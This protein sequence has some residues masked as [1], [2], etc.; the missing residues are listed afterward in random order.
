MM[1]SARGRPSSVLW[2]ITAALVIALIVAAGRLAVRRHLQAAELA[3][4]QALTYLADLK[5]DELS[6]WFRERRGDAAV[7]RS[8]AVVQRYLAA[9]S[10]AAAGAV[11]L[12]YFR[13]LQRAYDYRAVAVYD[14]RATPLLKVG[15]GGWPDQLSCVPEH[16]RR[17]LR[18]GE[19]IVTELHR[20]S[21]AEPVH[22]SVLCPVHLAPGG[23]GP[24]DGVVLLVID[25][26]RYLYPML[27]NQP[28]LT[29]SGE[30]LLVRRDGQEV[31]YLG[32]FRHRAGGALLTRVSLAKT[33]APTVRAAQGETGLMRGAEYRGVDVLAVARPV[34][35]T[36]WSLLA[37]EDQAEV[38][39]PAWQEMRKTWTVMGLAVVALLLAA[40]LAW[41]QRTERRMRTELAERKRVQEE[42]RRSRELLR[43][44][45]DTIPQA[46]FWKDR[47][48]RYL[49]CNRTFAKL[50]GLPAPD[51][52]VGLSDFD[53]PWQRSESEAYRAD[54]RAVVES[55]RAKLHIIE[56]QL[57][58][59]G[60]LT[61][62]DTS[63]APLFDEAGRA[64]GVLGVYDD[65][66]E[67]R[68]LEEELQDRNEELVRFVYTVSHDLR[69][70]LVTIQTFL[71]YLEKD[72]AKG[73][74]ARV[75]A[76]FE[77]I[78]RAAAKMLQ[79]LEELLQLS[80]VGRKTNPFEDVPFRELVR[81]ALD[82]VAG[83]IAE[84]R[85]EVCVADSAAVLRCDRTRLVEVFQNLVD[86]AVK[87][88]GDQ[89][90]PRI[91]IGVEAAG[92]D[93]VCHVRDNGQGIDPRHHS[94][95]FGLFEK[96][97]PGTPGSGMGLA[98]VK[99]IIE[100]HGGRVWAESGGVGQGATFRFTIPAPHGHGERGKA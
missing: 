31:V 89:P 16:V 21:A 49:G 90:A 13:E 38:E 62:V 17:A 25:P 56:S 64:F 40:G 50:A 81:A 83:Q 70:P 57:T 10:D 33:N 9:P 97:H 28:V 91:D 19:S 14:A 68:R 69:S 65:I 67:R 46:V 100:V 29:R 82:A 66:T 85:V 35:G 36:S 45:L 48:S 95:L 92:G 5:A 71:G 98:L 61:W 94:K 87:F 99:R 41:R 80:R 7:V 11:V 26:A 60:V 15:E 58:A 32:E 42:L 72:L 22:L 84:R 86:N 44:V 52:I 43:L 55:A 24:A 27:R 30:T 76:D 37:V 54:D 75:S 77:Y 93:L 3:A 63:K 53:L 78:R 2:L 74:P 73:D 51:A 6:T 47:E 34:P 8:S 59:E 96:L 1:D 4:E 79:L 20:C 23:A 18:S 12:A 88:M 39:E